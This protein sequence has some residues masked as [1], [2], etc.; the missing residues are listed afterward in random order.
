MRHWI[1]WVAVALAAF[2]VG[3]LAWWWTRPLPAV[4]EPAIAGAALY[5]ASFRD[6]SGQPRSLGELQGKVLVLNF[7]ATWCAPCREEMP[8]FERA[9]RRWRE[10]GVAFVGI[11]DEPPELLARFGRELG[12]TYALWS[13]GEAAGELSRRLGNRLAVLPFT[14][15]VD[16]RGRVVGAKVGP[17]TERELE[18]VLADLT[19]KAANVAENANSLLPRS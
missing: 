2:A 13:G 9:H 11:S 14:A 5:A 4:S 18:K 17:Y 19:G 12:I 1:A 10:K 7:W 6:S 15:L 3:G 16:P 8:A